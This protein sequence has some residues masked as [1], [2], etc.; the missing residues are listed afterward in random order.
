LRHLEFFLKTI[1]LSLALL[2]SLLSP[3]KL[4]GQSV[5]PDAPPVNPDATPAARALL[6][7]IDT[8]SGKATLSGEHN[9]PNTVSRYS[10][11]ICELTSKYPAV[12][13]QD[14]GF[15]GGED[16]DSTLGRP[17]MIQ[18]VIRQF[19]AARSLRLRGTLSDLPKM[20][21]SP[22]TIAFRDISR[23]GSSGR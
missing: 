4:P 15:S 13:G 10:D 21:L 7:E 11:R 2:V 1:F 6:H 17:S 12:F 18:E 19:A 23:I 8:M 14:F 20:N 16:K 3:L 9:F 5:Q 22:F